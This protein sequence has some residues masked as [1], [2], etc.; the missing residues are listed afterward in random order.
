MG[1]KPATNPEVEATSIEL[2]I[3]GKTVVAKDG[4]SLYNVKI[5]RAHV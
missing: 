3:D 2:S 1:L 5:G 4:V